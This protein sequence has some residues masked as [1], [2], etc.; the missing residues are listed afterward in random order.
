MAQAYTDVIERLAS[1][2]ASRP[3]GL[4]LEDGAEFGR[5]LEDLAARMEKAVEI[6]RQ[7][8]ELVNPQVIPQDL[9]LTPRELEMLTHLAEGRSNAEIARLCWISENTVKFHMKNI[10]RKLGVRD[11]GQAMMIA[12]AIQR[13]LDR[14]APPSPAQ[15]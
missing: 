11:R 1:T 4:S 14:G 15:S 13:R 7:L 12:R 2:L 10:F 8:V 5:A 3:G 9:H 6:L